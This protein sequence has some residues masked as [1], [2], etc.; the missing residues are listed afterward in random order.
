MTFFREEAGFYPHT[1]PRPA[2]SWHRV[3][4][5]ARKSNSI[6]SIREDATLGAGRLPFS[7][8]ADRPCV[9]MGAK[10]K[11]RGGCGVPVGRAGVVFR[12]AFPALVFASEQMVA[13]L[14]VFLTRSPRLPAFGAAR[15]PSVLPAVLS[16]LVGRGAFGDGPWLRVLTGWFVHGGV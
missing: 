5:N 3:G 16:P 6:K 10:P 12:V 8:N 14:S 15:A 13:W 7:R 2:V 11:R 1:S 4:H 9:L